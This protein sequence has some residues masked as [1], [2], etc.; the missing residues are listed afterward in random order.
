MLFEWIA[1][2]NRRIDA[3]EAIGAGPVAEMLRVLG[4]DNLLEPDDE[5]PDDEAQALLEQREAARRERDFATADARRG[6][7]AAR[8]WE[9]RDTADGPQLVRI[10]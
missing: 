9:V 1:E 6:E 10:R 4:L 8:G 2:V 5:A 3:G 7:L